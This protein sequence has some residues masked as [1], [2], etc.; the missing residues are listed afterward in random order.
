MTSVFIV[1]FEKAADGKVIRFGAARCEDDLVWTSIKKVGHLM[2]GLVYGRTRL[3]AEMMD[4]R[5]VAEFIG[6]VRHHRLKNRRID[7]RCG[8]VIEV[9]SAKHTGILTSRLSC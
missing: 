9:N 4:A 7:G 2:A 8:T 6:Q 1:H 5:C 3:L